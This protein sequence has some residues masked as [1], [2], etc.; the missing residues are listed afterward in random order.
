VQLR[1]WSAWVRDRHIPPLEVTREHVEAY[2]DHLEREGKAAGTVYGALSVLTSFYDHLIEHDVVT[3][4]PARKVPRPIVSD[5]SSRQAPSLEQCMTMNDLAALGDPREH[6]LFCLLF[7]N[8]LRVEEALSITLGALQH[9]NGRT[10]FQFIG[11]GSKP[12]LIALPEEPTLQVL[13]RCRAGMTDP[14]QRLLPW[15]R[16]QAN[17]LIQSLAVRANVRD[18]HVTPHS[19][20]HA[21]ITIGFDKGL[22]GSEIQAFARHSNP[23]TTWRYNRHKAEQ[24][25]RATDGIAQLAVNPYA[26]SA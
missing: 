5:E 22:T 4:N 8:A 6:L 3:K 15:D 11:K 20:R 13:E 23:Q 10:L 17:R 26:R 14:T 19:L 16:H 18:I 21:A 1:T 25:T 9:K 24:A 7:F 2:R 12:A